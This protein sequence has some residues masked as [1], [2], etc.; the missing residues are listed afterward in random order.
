MAC[1][2]AAKGLRMRATISPEPALLG[3]LLGGPLH[4]YDLY[5]QVNRRLGMV[6]H[7]GLSQMYA[8]FNNYAA[9]GWLRT[10][11]QAQGLR[12]SKK[13]LELTPAGSRAFETW[14]N[15]PAR[16]LREFRIDF[17]LRLYFTRALGAVATR[18]LIERQIAAS[19]KEL[20]TLH[21]YEAASV[22]GEDNFNRLTRS[23]RIQQLT[24]I[25]KWLE[26]NRSDLIQSP[27]SLRMTDVRK[28]R[29]SRRKKPG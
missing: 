29:P 5:K 18:R 26:D 10:R 22:D 9:Q 8:I 2:S 23:F 16:G 25:L 3:F 28:A 4:G 12:P 27:S 14:L 6:W 13:I 15:Q 7:L 19:Q 17:F 11:T 21:A 24:T 20:E 1:G